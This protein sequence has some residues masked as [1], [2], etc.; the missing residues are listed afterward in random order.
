M[1]ASALFTGLTKNEC[2]E[3][4]SCG[5]VR[6]FARD[7][8]LFAQG[9]PNRNLTMVLSGSV[10]LTQISS[11]GN[12]VLLWMS[13]KG[14]PVNVS[15]ESESCSHTCSARA[16]EH[17]RA[18]VWEYSR[19]NSLLD[20]YPQIR[21][22]INRILSSRLSELEERFR[23]VAT[24]KA[25]K[26]LALALTRLLKQVGKPLTDGIQVSLSREE[27]AQ[28]TGTTLFTISR[29][30]SKW[31]ERGFVVP[32]REAV[33]VMDQKMLEYADDEDA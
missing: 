9:D 17:C 20:Q 28:M 23:E 29:I 15:A 27:L 2:L 32:R 5:R 11:G 14:D 7:E 1:C 16:V 21:D 4:A 10:K 19:L 12:E 22:N 33:V 6:T 18:L 24:E 8:L 13:G 26:R 3:I 25:A 30:L 31:A